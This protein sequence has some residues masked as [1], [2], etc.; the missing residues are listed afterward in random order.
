MTVARVSL[1]AWSALW[2]RLGARSDPAPAHGE[3]HRAYSEPHRHYHTLEHIAHALGRFDGIRS[4]VDAAD[5][6]ELALWL[7]DFVYDPRAKDNEARSAA[8]ARRL[9]AEG[10]VVPAVGERVTD[11]I[12]ATCHVSPP[13]A[14]DARYVVDADLSILGAPAAE[15]DRYERQVRQEYAFVSGLDWRA[16]RARIL[17]VFLDRPRIFLTPEFAALEG[18]ARA[19]LERSIEALQRAP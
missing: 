13:D 17:R 6:A 7:H 9:L 15:F 11:L 12:M 5:A 8:Y 4:R 3:I 18:P 2:R 10:G 19:N 14:P 16:G 1:E